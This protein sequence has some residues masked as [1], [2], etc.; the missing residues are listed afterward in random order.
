M[1]IRDRSANEGLPEGTIGIS[2]IAVSPTNN[3]NIYAIIEA[4]EG[5]VFRSRD[6][7]ET[8]SNVNDDRNMRQ[9][10]WYYTRIYADPTD[11]ESLYVLNV[12]FHYSKD[13]GRS[14]S[15]IDT[16]HGDNHDLWIDPA[17]PLRMIQ[18]NDGGANVSYDPVSYTH[19]TLPTILLV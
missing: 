10:A 3:K 6:G 9:R 2:G 8:W 5:G 11:E 13:G 4:E 14:F 18:A 15:E 12:R 16:P 1:C 17:D 19:L 7:G